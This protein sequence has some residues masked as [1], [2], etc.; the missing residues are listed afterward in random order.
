MKQH[1]KKLLILI[2]LVFVAGAAFAAYSFVGPTAAPTS[3]NTDAPLDISST[4]Q[5]KNGGLAVG[6]FQARSGSD[7][8]QQSQFTGL[9]NGG[10]AGSTNSTITI[11][12]SSD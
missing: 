7:F 1:L 4:N 2:P 12:N 10:T 11:G 6:T 9:V 3:N 5:I 8:A